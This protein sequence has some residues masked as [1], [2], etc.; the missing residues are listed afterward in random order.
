MSG[1]AGRHRDALT[2]SSVAAAA[3]RRRQRILLLPVVAVC[4]RGGGAVRRPGP[5]PD[6]R[7]ARAGGSDGAAGAGLQLLVFFFFFFFFKKKKKKK[8]KKKRSLL[9]QR[10]PRRPGRTSTEVGTTPRRPPHRTASRPTPRRRRQSPTSP[11]D[12]TSPAAL[13]A[14]PLGSL[15]VHVQ[16]DGYRSHRTADTHGLVEHHARQH[17]LLGHRVEPEVCRQDAVPVVRVRRQ[18][19]RLPQR[20]VEPARQVGVGGAGPSR[21]WRTSSPATAP[22]CAAWDRVRETGQY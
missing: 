6:G 5:P 1:Y 16:H 13:A 18:R 22:P 21:V 7:R 17:D 14:S 19:V 11:A 12:E 9:R 3:N 15:G 2:G 8:K 20:D 10:R 4:R